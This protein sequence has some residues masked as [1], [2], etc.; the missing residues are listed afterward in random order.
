MERALKGSSDSLLDNS[1]GDRSLVISANPYLLQS[2][3]LAAI[4]I[5]EEDHYQNIYLSKCIQD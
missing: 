5:R 2:C 4:H 1:K 3:N